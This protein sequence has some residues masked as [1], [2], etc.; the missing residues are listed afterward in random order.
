[1]NNGPI[2]FSNWKQALAQSDLS[3]V[4]QA[5]Y[6]REILT[7]LHHCKKCHSPVTVEFIKQWLAGPQLQVR[8]AEGYGR[9]RRPGPGGLAVVLSPCAKG[10]GFQCGHT[11][12]GTDNG[13]RKRLG[14]KPLHRASGV[15]PRS[16]SGLSVVALGEVGR[17]RS[18]SRQDG[19]TTSAGPTC[20]PR[21]RLRLH[22]SPRL[23]TAR[24]RGYA[25]ALHFPA[26]GCDRLKSTRVR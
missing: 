25:T 21:F 1:M 8:L 16:A 24:K 13:Q 10:R 22:P 19:A 7:L 20:G 26:Q 15:R 18:T 6:N 23:R 3:P 5:V 17:P 4:V 2:S 9:R 12:T 11:A 14:G